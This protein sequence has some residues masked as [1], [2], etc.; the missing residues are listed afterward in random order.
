MQER[1]GP[2]GALM[3]EYKHAAAEYVRAIADVPP[4]LYEALLDP[5]TENVDLQSIQ[6]ICF[7]VLFAGYAYANAIRRRFGRNIASPERF[8]PTQEDFSSAMTNML[9]YTVESLKDHYGMTD[10]E[11]TATIIPT[12]WS[13]HHDF[14]ALLE[15]AIVH[16]LRHRR[17]VERL[18]LEANSTGL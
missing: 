6:G 3:L 2:V 7:H 14:E 8:Q 10:D 18:V 13:D 1:R 4:E 11:M 12:R 9:A 16:L 5:A 15:H 17:Q